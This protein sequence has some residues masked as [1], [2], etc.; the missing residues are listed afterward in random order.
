[1]LTKI[2]Y[3]KPATPL[4]SVIVKAIRTMEREGYA[5]D[6]RDRY[7]WVWQRLLGHA[8]ARNRHE[9][10]A[11]LCKEFLA[12]YGTA[13]TLPASAVRE[14]VRVARRAV[15]TL[16]RLSMHGEWNPYCPKKTPPTL[17]TLVVDDLQAYL[18]YLKDERHFT[19][20]TLKYHKVTVED[21]VV[22][23]GAS[24]AFRWTELTPSNIS[25]F[26]ASKAGLSIASLERFSY[27]L[28]TFFRF[29]FVAGRVDQDWSEYVP[30]FRRFADQQ[31]PV[32]WPRD[33]VNT[34][35]NSVNR[36]SIQGKR[37]YAILLLAARLGMRAGDISALRLE[38][39]RWD[40]ARI[41]YT[42]RKTGNKITLPLT[43]EVGDA[44][45]DYIL[46]AR[47]ATQYREV[48]L[49]CRA[50]YRP[51]GCTINHIMRK[52]RRDAQLVLPSGHIGVHSLRHT[53]ARQLL[54]NEMPLETIAAILGHTSL[55]ATRIYA[56]VDVQQLRTAALDPEEVRHA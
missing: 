20:K 7:R 40:N 47:P 15:R 1:M 30:H 8:T 11:Q 45:I 12:T 56:K 9:L 28:R 18:Q 27:V 36:D 14:T 34:L 19:P 54:A 24:S 43:D 26:F 32:I 16:L 22:F 29:I 17:P 5:A 37:N 39:L 33:A 23:R 25:A 46:Q 55:S 53:L 21:F 3:Q 2:N 52:H 44:L 13:E 6:T 42:Q 4:E 49:R 10:T 31:L 41:E 38:S 48:F 50:P 35:L 51:I